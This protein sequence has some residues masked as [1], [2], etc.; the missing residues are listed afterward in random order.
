M[1]KNWDDLPD[2][3]KNKSV[4]MYYE[5]LERK[6]SSLY[7]KRVFDIVFGV[8]AL[9]VLLPFF[10]IISM[11][12]KLD[13]GGPVMFRQVRA[14]QY[15]R[16]FWICKFRTMI[17]DAAG[18]GSKLTGGKDK[19]ITRVGGF[20][21]KYRLDELAQIF[22]II[23]GDMSF[24]GTRPEVLQ[25]VKEYTDEMKATLLLP[26]GLTSE[27]SIRYVNEESLLAGS[28]DRVKI[29]VEYI[30]PEKMKINLDSIKKFSILNDIKTIFRTMLWICKGDK[31]SDAATASTVI[32]SGKSIGE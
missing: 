6:R 18:T 26:A 2:N 7:A 20:L 15:G 12:I 23:A 28:G 19:R 21:R 31:S 24:V 32:A 11:A 8:I 3:M 13:S 9:I 16:P 30:L 5:M 4:K 14:T 29:Y 27:T 17:I 25:F 22:N 10:I 1:L